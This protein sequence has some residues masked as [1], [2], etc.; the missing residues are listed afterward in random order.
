L[1]D[2]CNQ[3]ES[4][5]PPTPQFNH[6]PILL[7]VVGWR[8]QKLKDST[9]AYVLLSATLVALLD[10]SETTISQGLPLADGQLL[11]GVVLNLYP[12][13]ALQIA[14]KCTV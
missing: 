1:Q 5:T 6:I 10:W 8:V 9:L 11:L 12:K 13:W 3:F 14:H 7:F 2:V 4:V